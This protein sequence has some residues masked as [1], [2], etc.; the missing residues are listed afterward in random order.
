MS[1]IKKIDHVLRSVIKA[2]ETY[3]IV[4]VGPIGQQIL[5]LGDTFYG[6]RFTAKEFTAVWSASDHQL[7]VFDCNG[8]RLG[9]SILDS[10]G[11]MINE[12]ETSIRIS[13][14][15]QNERNAA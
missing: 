6:Y 13:D 14:K 12:V 4:D 5:L 3:G 10:A 9:C 1:N 7:N 8:K 11:N 15:N 2:A